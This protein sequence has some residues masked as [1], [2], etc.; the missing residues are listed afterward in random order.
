MAEVLRRGDRSPGSMDELAFLILAPRARIDDGAFAR[1]ADP[2]AILRKV[3]RRAAEYVGE[4]DDWVRD[5][6]EPTLARVDIRCLAWEEAIETVAFHAPEAGQFIDAFYGKCLHFNRPAQRAVYPGPRTG[7]N[8][9][10]SYARAQAAAPY[11]V[12]GRRL[13]PAAH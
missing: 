11:I 8:R 1:D 3:R 6:F 2:D 7:A 13:E 10:W 9:P 5:W 4:R 12:E